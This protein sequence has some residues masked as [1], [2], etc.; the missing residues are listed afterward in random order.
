MNRLLKWAAIALG[1][2]ISLVLV[3]LAFI[4]A[5]SEIILDRK[6]PP[7]PEAGLS[8][9]ATPELAAS[10]AHLAQIYGCT[11]CHGATLAG[12]Q[13][14]DIPD[15]TVLWSPNLPLLAKTYSGAD[16]DRAIRYGLRADR[17]SVVLMPSNA[18]T[19]LGDDEVAA[20]V[21]YVRSLQ[22]Q[23]EQRPRRHLGL[24]VRAGLVFGIFKTTRAQFINAK[25]AFDLGPTYAVGRHLA[26]NGCAECHGSDLTGGTAVGPM[27]A[28]PDLGLV[29]A[30]DRDDFASFMRTGKAA[31]NRELPM[32]SDAA[33]SRFSYF[34]DAEVN[35]LYDYLGARGK[36]L[37]AREQ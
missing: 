6:Y 15:G 18:Y 33:R 11:S 28:R 22:A 35:A 10:G 12:G 36:T 17:T 32:M 5:V 8:V 20:L 30:Y 29:A 21:A 34:T 16:F 37:A 9:V 2:L 25:P 4:Y 3:A 24:M 14:K 19:T 7:P 1:G 27:P 26:Q 31:G 23:G 13:F